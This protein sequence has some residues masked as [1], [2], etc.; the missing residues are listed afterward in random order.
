ML[1]LKWDGYNLT[2]KVEIWR[3]ILFIRVIINRIFLRFGKGRYSIDCDYFHRENGK[4]LC[5]SPT[6]LSDDQECSEECQ[7]TAREV[8]FNA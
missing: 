6:R 8:L 7:R 4:M 1:K 3:V 5:R 2:L